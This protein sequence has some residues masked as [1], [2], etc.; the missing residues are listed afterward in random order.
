MCG[1]NEATIAYA[2]A[3]QATYINV[4]AWAEDEEAD[5]DG[6]AAPRAPRTHLVIRVRGERAEA[7]LL[8]WTGAEARPYG[9]SG[10][11]DSSDG[12][13]RYAES[14]SIE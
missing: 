1:S 12:R 8:A 9:T 4:G 6:A 10:A 13:R 5:E 14:A 3:G 7:E 11:V 2:P